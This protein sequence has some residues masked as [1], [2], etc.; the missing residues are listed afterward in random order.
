MCNF[1]LDCSRARRLC[2][3]E[4][5]E[6]VGRVVPDDYRHLKRQQTQKTQ[7]VCFCLTPYTH[8]YLSNAFF[9][10]QYMSS[11]RAYGSVLKL[12]VYICAESSDGT[13]A[14]VRDQVDG[15]KHIFF[16]RYPEI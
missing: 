2:K 14:A 15:T 13:T 16:T 10:I 9:S 1:S 12:G 7:T 6:F 4:H 8:F 11:F 5:I 3:K